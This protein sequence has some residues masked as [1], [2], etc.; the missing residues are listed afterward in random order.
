M[1]T[2]TTPNPRR[3]PSI[4]WNDKSY[5]NWVHTNHDASEFK[6]FDFLRSNAIRFFNRI[7][8]NVAP[9]QQKILTITRTIELDY[10]E[11]GEPLGDKKQEYCWYTIEYSGKDS[12][13]QKI[14][15]GTLVEGRHQILP[16]EQQVSWRLVDGHPQEEIKTVDAPHVIKYTIPWEGKKT[17]DTII[18]KHSNQNRKDQILY[19]VKFPNNSI[20]NRAYYTYDQFV[21]SDY[22]HARYLA[23]RA[24][25][26]TGQ[27]NA[28]IDPSRI[29]T[30]CNCPKC[31]KVK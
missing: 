20:T 2:I 25:G 13:K 21:N 8:L 19:C 5:Q 24:G 11:D 22:E 4:T 12:W 18:D 29:Q 3:K 31:L 30:Q 15:T 10:N 23:N 17:V 26:T 27:Y 7:D 9:L 1:S 16:Q 14:S 6:G 28:K